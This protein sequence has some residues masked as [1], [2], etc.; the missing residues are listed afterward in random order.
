MPL[1]AAGLVSCCQSF[2]P[3]A[4]DVTEE[5]P[6]DPL[7]CLTGLSCSREIPL[8]QHHGHRV[9]QV[10]LTLLLHLPQEET[11]GLET[12]GG[13]SNGFAQY[14]CICFEVDPSPFLG[15]FFF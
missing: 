11:I 1:R 9:G 8:V 14:Y 5:S 12:M 13:G 4:G 3:A 15:G 2:T 7:L 10:G 6:Q